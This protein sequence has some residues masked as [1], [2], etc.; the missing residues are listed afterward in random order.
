MKP[1]EFDLGE[2]E[3]IPVD[4]MLKLL[5]LVETGGEAHECSDDSEIKVNGA[6]ELQ[7]RKKLRHG[8]KVAFRGVTILIHGQQK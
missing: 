4:K 3:F 7:R 1:I 8:D 5:G 6:I 2:H